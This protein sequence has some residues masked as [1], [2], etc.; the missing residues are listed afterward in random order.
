MYSTWCLQYRV[1]VFVVHYCLETLCHSLLLRLILF[2]Q[3]NYV[4]LC[5]LPVCW[6]RDQRLAKWM[7]LWSSN[8]H[9]WEPLGGFKLF[10][11]GWVVTNNLKVSELKPPIL[12]L[13]QVDI[14]LSILCLP[15]LGD[16]DAEISA[17]GFEIIQGHGI[18]SPNHCSNF[19]DGK[20]VKCC[21]VPV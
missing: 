6:I 9:L 18:T 13:L 4:D 5:K 3:R 11:G 16:E 7:E 12:E 17:G 14:L 8:V 10:R 21:L 19:G 15:W 2:R 1:L 20:C